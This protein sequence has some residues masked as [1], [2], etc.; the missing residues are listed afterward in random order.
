MRGVHSEAAGSRR[1]SVRIPPSP[2]RWVYMHCAAQPVTLVDIE[3]LV[4]EE[5]PLEALPVVG[6][7]VLALL[8]PSW[9]VLADEP[10]DVVVPAA[11]PE[12]VCDDPLADVEVEA[13]PVPVEVGEVVP[14]GLWELDW[15]LPFPE[16]DWPE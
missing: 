15:S 3:L 5:P 12:P 4:C 2:P 11:P 7:C 1:A 10:V 8:D 9:P 14:V 13:V 16:D 6:D